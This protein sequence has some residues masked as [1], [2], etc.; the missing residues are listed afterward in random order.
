MEA[1]PV[2]LRRRGFNQAAFAFLNTGISENSV[3]LFCFLFHE[4]P[5]MMKLR[6]AQSKAKGL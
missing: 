4:I 5:F 2:K 3:V 1:N 6:R